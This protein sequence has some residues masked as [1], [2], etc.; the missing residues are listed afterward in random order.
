MRFCTLLTLLFSPSNILYLHQVWRIKYCP[1]M[2][3]Y[4]PPPV[5]TKIHLFVTLFNARQYT[6]HLT[7]LSLL[8]MSTEDE[9]HS[10]IGGSVTS[11]LIIC[12]RCFSSSPAKQN[13]LRLRCC[14]I[15]WE[16]PVSIQCSIA[17]KLPI[18]YSLV[19]NTFE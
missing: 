10:E 3:L 13:G 5:V 6:Y 2:N 19:E 8:Q 16:S 17:V 9:A 14:L 1:T 18:S 12:S 15:G 7:L 4:S 11:A